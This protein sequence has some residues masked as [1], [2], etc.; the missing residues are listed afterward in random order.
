[1][2]TLQCITDITLAIAVGYEVKRVIVEQ[3][4]NINTVSVFRGQKI[5]EKKETLKLNLG[6]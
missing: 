4:W 6:L 5:E 1:M 3:R 2:C